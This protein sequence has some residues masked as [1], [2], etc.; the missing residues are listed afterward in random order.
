MLILYLL[1]FSCRRMVLVQR[2]GRGRRGW[3]G[4]VRGA[5]MREERGREEGGAEM[6]D[7]RGRE[8]GGAE[9]RD[10]WGREEE[11]RSKKDKDRNE[12]IHNL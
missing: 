1:S 4:K 6:R 12:I 7:E 2:K 8:E 10:K 9:M 5:E 11:D 3:R